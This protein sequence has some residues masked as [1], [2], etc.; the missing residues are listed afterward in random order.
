MPGVQAVGMDGIV[1]SGQR[2]VRTQPTTRPN[3]NA[4]ERPD[5]AGFMRRGFRFTIPEVDFVA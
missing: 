3:Y 4:W 1:T 2:L 5:L